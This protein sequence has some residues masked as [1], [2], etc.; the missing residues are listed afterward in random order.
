M[1]T[2]APVK[3]EVWIDKPVRRERETEA[4]DAAPPIERPEREREPVKV[5]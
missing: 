3:R 4:P 1:G 5:S 2:Q